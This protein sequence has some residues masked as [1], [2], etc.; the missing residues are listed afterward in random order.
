[1][2]SLR[3]VTP[4]SAQAAATAVSCP[5]HEL[6]RPVRIAVPSTVWTSMF[7]ASSLALR[8]KAFLMECL[9]SLAY[10]VATSR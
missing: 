4:G 3:A 10:G 6:M 1:M 2:R 9:T 5:A 8:A 7:L